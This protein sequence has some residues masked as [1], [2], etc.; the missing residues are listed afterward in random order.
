[1]VGEVFDAMM[2]AMERAGAVRLNAPRSTPSTKAAIASVGEGDQK[3]DVPV[4][5]FIGQDAAVL[6]RA[7]GKNVAARTWSCSSARRTSRI[8]SCRWSR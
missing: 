5:E 4:K 6:A 7:A 1:M 3:H 8:P 2:A